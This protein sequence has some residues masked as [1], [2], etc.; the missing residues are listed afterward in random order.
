VPEERCGDHC[1]AP[2]TWWGRRRS[3]LGRGRATAA[4]WDAPRPVLLAPQSLERL[5][6]VER[7]RYD[8]LR[9]WRGATAKEIGWPAFR[10]SPNRTLAAIAVRDPRDEDE[11]LAVAGVGPWL[12]EN[13]G[14]AV[15][16]VLNAVRAAA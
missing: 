4:A 5:D 16:D 7:A 6:V 14:A 10:V 15:L 1:E 8:A 13:Y 11:L 2:A 9:V 3:A 12:I